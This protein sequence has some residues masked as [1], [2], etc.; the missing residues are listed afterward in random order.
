MNE[1][2]MVRFIGWN[3]D[4]IV[5]SEVHATDP[6]PGDVGVILHKYVW[7]TDYPLTVRFFRIPHV[8]TSLAEDEVELVG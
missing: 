4:E 7:P 1:G 8:T 3:D 5:E 6:V 2:D